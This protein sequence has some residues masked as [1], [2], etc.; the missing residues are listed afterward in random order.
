MY[1][2]KDKALN[3]LALKTRKMNIVLN[4]H[5]SY[6]IITLKERKL[7]TPSLLNIVYIISKIQENNIFYTED[8]IKITG[9][10]N[11]ESIQSQI[12]NLA[13]LCIC[14][15]I[16]K[17]KYR[18][19]RA[20]MRKDGI[21]LS[22]I[23][24]KFLKDIERIWTSTG[25]LNIGEIEHKLDRSNVWL[26]H[27]FRVLYF[28]GYINKVNYKDYGTYWELIRRLDGSL[29]EKKEFPKLENLIYPVRYIEVENGDTWK[30]TYWIS[31]NWRF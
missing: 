17:T 14:E 18:L 30:T 5:L 9:H 25:Y 28:A 16:K 27:K 6:E 26:Y 8:I 2:I 24:K 10:K 29:I 4:N 13:D 31:S 21:P 11:V 12:N 23:E 3:L 15:C 20:N 1:E 22:R 7:L 19:L